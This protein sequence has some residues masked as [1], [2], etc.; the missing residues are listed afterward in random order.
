[1]LPWFPLLLCSNGDL[2]AIRCKAANDSGISRKP[3]LGGRKPVC[4]EN[5]APYKTTKPEDDS[6]P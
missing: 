3:L 5:E 6:R 4:L 1:M 2:D